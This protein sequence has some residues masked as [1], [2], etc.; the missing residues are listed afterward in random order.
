MLRDMPYLDLLRRRVTLNDSELRK[1]EEISMETEKH[2]EVIL[3]EER[4]L[5]KEELLKVKS[6]FYGCEFVDLDKAKLDLFSARLIP[7]S[8]CER[9]RVLCLN[10]RGNEL[11]GL[12]ADPSDKFAKEYIRIRTGYTFSS[13]VGFWGDMQKALQDAFSIPESS[14]SKPPEPLLPRT[15]PEAPPVKEPPAEATGESSVEHVDRNIHKAF[16]RL[17]DDWEIQKKINEISMDLGT[18]LDKRTLIP[19]ILELA[20]QIFNAEGVSL[21]LL[22]ENQPFLYFS[23]V[24]GDKES[25][26][27]NMMIPLDERSVA[28]WIV[29]NQRPV[30]SNDVSTDFRH[31]KVVDE[32]T[33]FITRSIIGVPVKYGKNVLGVLEAVN[34][35]D[36]GFTQNELEHMKILASHAAIALKNAEIYDKLKNFTV[37]AVELLIDFL[38]YIEEDLK[39][40]MVEVARITASIGEKL[41]FSE[42]EL[43]NIFHASLL[44]DIGVLKV[45]GGD[46]KQHPHYSAEILQHIKLFEGLIPYVISHHER[47]DGTGYPQGLKGDEI[48]LG[49]QILALAEA[50]VEGLHTSGSGDMDEYVRS[51]LNDFGH[52]YSPLLRDPFIAT[53]DEGSETQYLPLEMGSP[54]EDGSAAL[55][56]NG[57]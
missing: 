18:H 30:I 28:G 41:G 14:I 25:E 12:M 16:A 44:H 24:L 39:G 51:F 45:R 55:L 20:R 49:A 1:I 48:P 23:N 47:F 19:K 17:K 5:S 36:G 6:E 15:P 52:G 26:I 40:H 37:E 13:K 53:I 10:L 33:Q 50:F 42:T 46:M 21:I 11:E 43:E 57:N 34:K 35:K 7:R 31:S 2:P 27:E 3:I 8:M 32:T 9:Y 22:Q 56:R 38:D 54:V 4:I 29:I